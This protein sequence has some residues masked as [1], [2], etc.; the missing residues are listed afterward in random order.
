[1]ALL[2]RN[3]PEL[4]LCD[5]AAMHLG[6]A[7]VALY[8][9]SPPA[10]IAHVLADCEPRALVGE[11]D[12]LDGLGSLA[13]AVPRV[14]QFDDVL[15]GLDPPSG[16]SFEAAWSSVEP[17][18]LL[19]V[20]YTSGTTGLPKGVE[21]EH[22]AMDRCLRDFD[23]FLPDAEGGRDVSFAPFASIGE[24]AGGHWRS[25]IDA[26]TR[27]FCATPQELPGAL[28]ESRP[29]FIWAPPR[30]W[31]GL[32][33]ALESSLDESERATLDRALGAEGSESAAG[34]AG[35]GDAE[36]LA[37]LRGRLGLDRIECALT[38]AAPCP[39]GVRAFFS[40]LGLP[41]GEFYGMT[42]VGVCA[43]TGFDPPALDT[44][45]PALPGC[46]LRLAGDGEVL[47][48]CSGQARGYRNLPVET[49]GTFVDGWI[50]TGDLGR[51]DAHGELRLIDRKKELLIPAGGHNVAPSAI[52]LELKN[53]CPAIGQVCVVGD[54]RPHLGALIVLEPPDRALD[55]DSLAAV[56][57]A[58]EA[59]NA[60]LDPRERIEAHA[61]LA[62]PW[63]PG[64]ELT[65]TM[66][67]RRRRISERHEEAIE[68]LYATG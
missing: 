18:D 42:E 53:A 37:G 58:I 35:A 57:A 1:V 20:L 68:A 27:T 55:P 56:E 50:H 22:G 24:R 65:E 29:T 26:T 23:S 31:Q 46:E 17:G 36:L 5:A 9:A 33:A 39:T 64:E 15:A 14:V 60:G 38:A 16:F 3:R 25:M 28:L 11:R 45:G 30:L 7:T 47:V 63:L 12:L 19:A 41:F 4:A 67:L 2:S 40:A 8:T 49:A 34:L 44:V 66:K 61:V 54:A 59:V 52:E 48:R 32:K 10:T 43:C 51:I 6:A 13:A 21:W 62:D